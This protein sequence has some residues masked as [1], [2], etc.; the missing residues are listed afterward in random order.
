MK[1]LHVCNH[2]YPC[3]GG[4]ERYVFD[5]CRELIKKGHKSDVACLNTCAYSNEKLPPQEIVDEIT[6]YRMPYINL[7]YYKIAPS[8]LRL[9]KDYDVIHIHG[10]GFFSDY[11]V[12]TKWLH[13]KPL[14]LSTHGGIFAT[15]NLSVIKKIYFNTVTRLTLRKMKRIIATGQNEYN[16]FSKISR[17]IMNI[18]PGINYNKFSSIKRTVEKNTFLFVGRISKNKRIDNLIKTMGA[19]K[20]ADIKLYIVGEDWGGLMNDLKEISKSVGV[21]KNVIFTGK[22]S[23]NGLLKY[24]AKAEFFTSA[25]EYEGFGI[26]VAEAMAAGSIPILNDIEAFRAL[27]DDGKS[28]FIVD[29]SNPDA[30]AKRITE[31]NNLSQNKRNMVENAVKM[32]AKEYDW[33]KT[34]DRIESIYGELL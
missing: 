15:K 16:I 21:D 29:F 13:K 4:I 27:I 10:I 19:L 32:T 24:Y 22:I 12:L 28:G 1:I 18:S 8:I 3:I 9:A 7:K 25:S 5:L 23:D 26:S 30:A 14:V 20:C 33:S 2:F 31:I 6:V 11:L 34:A 17:N